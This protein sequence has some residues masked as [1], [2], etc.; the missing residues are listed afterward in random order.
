MGKM[1]VSELNVNKVFYP[2]QNELLTCNAAWIFTELRGNTAHYIEL[3]IVAAATTSNS[4]NFTPYLLHTISDATSC[5]LGQCTL[6]LFVAMC[7]LQTLINI[8][9]LK[10][11]VMAVASA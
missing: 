2:E 1:K 8:L 11:S 10:R 9:G 6:L 7:A 3:S 5:Y 4:T